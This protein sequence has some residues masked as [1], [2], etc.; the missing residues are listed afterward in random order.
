VTRFIWAGALA[1]VVGL[2]AGA[3]RAAAQQPGPPR[4]G[5]APPPPGYSPYLNLIRGGNRGAAYYG[6]IRPQQY[7][8]GAI[9]G[10][11]TQEQSLASGAGGQPEGTELP[12]TGVPAGFM[13][14]QV[15]FMNL[16]AAG[17]G[18]GMTANRPGGSQLGAG[19]QAPAPR[20]R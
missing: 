4:L 15:Y 13:T 2:W 7:F 5:S 8:Q 6:I 17:F 19:V 10:L 12:A 3:D 1:A 16:G 18:T 9:Q 20:T 14:H 11:Q